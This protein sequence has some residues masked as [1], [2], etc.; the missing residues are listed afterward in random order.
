MPPNC[1]TG[2][3]LPIVPHIGTT[4]LT[5]T[6]PPSGAISDRLLSENASNLGESWE[7][8][9]GNKQSLAGEIEYLPDIVDACSSTTLVFKEEFHHA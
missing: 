2:D 5:A 4:P 9:T 1:G 8:T 7:V 6:I 3:R